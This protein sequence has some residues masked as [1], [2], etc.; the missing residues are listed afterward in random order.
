MSGHGRQ[1]DPQVDE[2]VWNAWVKKHAEKDRVRA[3]RRKKIFGFLISLAVVLF[4]IWR[5]TN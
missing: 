4:V 2:A 3:A 1:D 5:S